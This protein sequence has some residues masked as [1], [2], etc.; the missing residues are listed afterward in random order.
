[1]T[2]VALTIAGSDSGGGA[3]IQQDLK[4]FEA[5]GVWGATALTA[6]TVQD[7]RGVHAVHP[8]PAA[9]VAAQ[10]EVVAADL[11]PAAVKTGM[12]AGAETLAAVCDAIRRAHLG[13]LV[14]DPVLIASDGTSLTD[15]DGLDIMRERLIPL[16]ALITP[17]ADE[18]AALTGASVE[19]PADQEKAARALVHLGAAAALVTGGHL[20]GDAED[21][22]F[23]G[24]SITRLTHAR[25]GGGPV[26]GTGCV[27]SAGIAAG[28][29]LGRPLGTAVRDAKD[30]V[31]GAIERAA[32]LGS[33]SRVADAAWRTRPP[34]H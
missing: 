2:T 17:N 5:F 29:A 16:A 3:G 26:H 21:V 33:G 23:D 25:I 10:I 6:V 30:Y 1:M 14:V 28:L 22:L 18:A 8:V 9:I 34:G 7:T 19:S 12:L 27:L 15:P 24:E 32:S 20:S 31:T 4:V 13:P 11:R